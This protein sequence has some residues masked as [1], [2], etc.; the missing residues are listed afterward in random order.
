MRPAGRQVMRD[1]LEQQ[2]AEKAAQERERREHEAVCFPANHTAREA[3]D[4]SRPWMSTTQF[5]SAQQ[6][7]GPLTEALNPYALA[8]KLKT[9]AL[10]SKSLSLNFLMP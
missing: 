9:L 1:I 3:E 8:L 10:K 7:V 5:M 6:E 2:L 4:T